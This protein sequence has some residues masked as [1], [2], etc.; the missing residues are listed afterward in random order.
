MALEAAKTALAHATDLWVRSE[1]RGG[2]RVPEG[3]IRRYLCDRM[4]RAIA[5]RQ[6]NGPQ[7]SP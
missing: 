6:A 4:G 1:N 3:E 2:M 7:C 5:E